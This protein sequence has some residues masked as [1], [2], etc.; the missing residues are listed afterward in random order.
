MNAR[1]RGYTSYVDSQKDWIWLPEKPGTSDGFNYGIVYQPREKTSVPEMKVCF[2]RCLCV[3]FSMSH[4]E[5]LK[6]QS[7]PFLE[8]D[9]LF[10]N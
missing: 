10:Y 9:R 1:C 7:T 2:E 6:I 4:P 8:A 3:M 5:N